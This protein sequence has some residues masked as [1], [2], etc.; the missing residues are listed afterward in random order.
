MS[1]QPWRWLVR[2]PRPEGAT[3]LC[4]GRLDMPARREDT[5]VAAE[6]L[7]AWLPKGLV[8]RSSPRLRCRMLAEALQ[9]RRP[10]LQGFDTLDWLTEMNFGA[11]EGRHWAELPEA[12]LSAWT[13]DFSH[14]RP[15][16]D[17]ETTAEFLDRIRRGLLAA[18]WVASGEAETA[19]ENA[20]TGEKVPA[21]RLQRGKV[22][23]GCEEGSGHP[24]SG[25]ASEAGE[26]PEVWIAHAG[27]ISAMYWLA[28]AGEAIEPAPSGA[29]R[30][31]SAAQ[32][33]A[34]ATAMTAG[35]NSAA[36][37]PAVV[38]RRAASPHSP[39]LFGVESMDY[40]AVMAELAQKRGVHAGMA[41]E[42]VGRDRGDVDSSIDGYAPRSPDADKRSQD[43][44]EKSRTLLEARLADV[45]LPTAAQWP[46]LDIGFGQEWALFRR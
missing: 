31:V 39:I 42:G 45:M 15:G 34:V 44:R 37:G 22:F 7:A 14:H 29:A 28:H 13:D 23:S 3:G 1:V 26:T 35:K 9:R 30:R 10:D 5:E 21:A 46:K 33:A 40:P 2:H 18:G 27:V 6:R 24:L 16:G 32:M 20:S 11:W 17:G 38:E 19:P 12:E 8:V 4:Y 25:T 41:R 43:A 36:P